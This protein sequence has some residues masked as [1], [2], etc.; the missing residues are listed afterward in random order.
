M[1]FRSHGYLEFLAL[2]TRG[3]NL[4]LTD[5]E[6]IAQ[7]RIWS[8]VAAKEIGL[9]DEIGGLNEALNHAAELAGLTEWSSQDLLPPLDPQSVFMMEL[10]QATAIDPLGSDFLD[11]VTGG[12]D[13]PLSWQSHWFKALS[14]DLSKLNAFNDPRH[15][16]A[17]CLACGAH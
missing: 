6:T 4:S 2:V 16:Y 1:L 14:E 17:M 11:V 13:E 8:G 15:V 10:M 3:R 7:G 12:F 9:A 5:V